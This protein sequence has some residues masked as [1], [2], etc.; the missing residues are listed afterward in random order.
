MTCAAA[1]PIPPLV[2]AALLSANASDFRTSCG[3]DTGRLLCALAG[4]VDCRRMGESGT[5]HGVGSA[6]LLSGSRDA[7][8]VTVER[9]FARVMAAR[10][11]LACQPRARVLCGDWS[12]LAQH[13]PFDLVFCDG[14]GKTTDPEG[15]IDLVSVGGLLVMDDFAPS[16]DWPRRYRGEVDQLR[17]TYLSHPELKSVEVRVSV[18]EVVIVATRVSR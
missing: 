2:R 3:H 8:L 11:V 17:M 1:G 4:T 15:V 10:A 12:L 5:G 16:S 6:W 13:G 14:G 18:D 9:D 7:E